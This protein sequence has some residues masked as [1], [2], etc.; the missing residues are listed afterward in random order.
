MTWLLVITN[1]PPEIAKPVPDFVESARHE[2]DRITVSKLT[3]IV[4]LLRSIVP[5]KFMGH[6]GRDDKRVTA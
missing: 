4:N 2:V 5:A 6:P 3:F 1:E